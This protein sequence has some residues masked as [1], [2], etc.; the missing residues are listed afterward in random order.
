MRCRKPPCC[1]AA[2][3]ILSPLNETNP[4]PGPGHCFLLCTCPPLPPAT[5]PHL[6]ALRFPILQ[7]V[8]R[9][10]FHILCSFIYPHYPD[11]HWSD[12]LVSITVSQFHTG[13]KG[14]SKNF[15]RVTQLLS[16]DS[17]VYLPIQGSVEASEVNQSTLKMKKPKP[18]QDTCP[19]QGH[20]HPWQN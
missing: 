9:I 8:G 13:G 7:T 3:S 1:P 17:S 10:T 6:V 5:H 11:D 19:G 2:V 4:S 14:G 16:Q 15:P 20:S 18:R 12:G